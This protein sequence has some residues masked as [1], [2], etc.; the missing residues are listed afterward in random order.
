MEILRKD[1][2]QNLIINK[3][4]DFLN[5]LGWQENLI[6]FENENRGLQCLSFELSYLSVL[7]K[8]KHFLINLTTLPLALTH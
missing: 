1:E 7:M 4:Q 6:E 5:D 2:N 8:C 3:E